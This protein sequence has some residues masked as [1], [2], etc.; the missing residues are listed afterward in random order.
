MAT[1][2]LSEEGG[3]ASRDP[4]ARTGSTDLWTLVMQ[5]MFGFHAVTGISL[6]SWPL[7]CR[8][9]GLTAVPMC[10]LAMIMQAARHPP[11]AQE[12]WHQLAATLGYHAVHTDTLPATGLGLPQWQVLSVIC[13]CMPGSGA[14][15]QAAT[16]HPHRVLH[17]CS[18]HSWPSHLWSLYHTAHP[19]LTLAIGVRHSRG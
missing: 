9:C 19:P 3:G 8:L 7:S 11:V 12:C 16:A 10:C 5:T 1:E 4:I 18:D 14:P 13:C 6:V 17:F 15:C 2:Y